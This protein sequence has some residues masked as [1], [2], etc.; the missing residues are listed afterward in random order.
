VSVTQG[1]TVY[2]KALGYQN[3][4]AKTPLKISHVFHMAS[5]TKLLIGTG[6]QKLWEDGRL[7]LDEALITYL[8]WFQ[9]ADSRYP[10]ITIRQLLSH[11]S[12]MPDVL[13]YHWETPEIDDGALERYVRSS[14]VQNAHLLWDPKDGRFAYSNMGYEILGVVIATLA[15][16]SVEDW[17]AS[18]IFEP[19]GMSHS[20][21]LTFRRSKEEVC[22]PHI[23]TAEKETVLAAH[24]PYNRAHGP[25]ST[26]TSNLEDMIKWARA[27][28]TRSVLLPGTYK[29]A[30]SK[31]AFVP[32]NGEHICLSWFCREQKGYELYGHEGTDDGFRA[33]FWIC[34]ELDLSITVCSNLSGAP[35]KKINKGIF[36]LL[37]EE[38]PASSM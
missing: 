15:G 24:F 22:S 33:S 2:Q 10:S 26:L 37:L 34:P 9:M 31:Q 4:I 28:L 3:A 7:N 11:T 18:Q 38:F 21:L 29:E 25:S 6:I 17:I 27:N 12:G 14:E 19:L 5:V 13:D 20:T 30:W 35:V 8:P 32:N 36:D 1:D 16:E 23:K